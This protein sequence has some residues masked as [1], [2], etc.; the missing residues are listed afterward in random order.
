LTIDC[1]SLLGRDTGRYSSREEEEEE[2]E[3]E[4]DVQGQGAMTTATTTTICCD[5]G[6]DEDVVV[7]HRG[8]ET[9]T[10][11]VRIFKDIGYL[12][13]NLTWLFE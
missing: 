1:G 13:T 5:V 2:E 4:N 6:G 8:G 10:I 9:A 3:E 7:W 12:D 11:F